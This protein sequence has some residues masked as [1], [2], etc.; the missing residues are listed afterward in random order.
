MTGQPDN[1]SFTISGIGNLN[2]RYTGSPD[3]GPR[4]VMNNSPSYPKDIYQW[5]T[6]AG[7]ALPPVKGSEGFDS[8]PRSIRRPGDHGLG[9]FRLQ[10]LPDPP[11][12]G[13]RLQLRV[14]MFN[15]FNHARFNDFNRSAQFNTAGQLIN[16][17]AVLG[18]TGG[19]FGFGALTGT[20]RSAENPTR[21]EVLLLNRP[22]SGQPIA[23]SPRRYTDWG[24]VRELLF[25]FWLAA[26]PQNL[27][28]SGR[29]AFEAGDLLRAERSFREYLKEHPTSAEAL[30]NLGAICSRREQFREAVRASMRRRFRRIPS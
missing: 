17:P 12:E 8:A 18:G 10:K 29:Q 5:M 7:L 20:A 13:M 9:R 3:V 19:R 26:V 22:G 30:S 11:K 6:P 25:G 4:I 14:E 2:E 15:A 16:T 27:L 23:A 24:M 21:G 1:L 28:D